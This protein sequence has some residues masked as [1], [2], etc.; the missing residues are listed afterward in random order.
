[1]LDLRDLIADSAT[2]P[3]TLDA[4]LHFTHTG[5]DTVI[6]VKPDGAAGQV[7]QTIVLSG[8]DLTAN[9]T[10]ND[11]TIIQDLLTKGKLITD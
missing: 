8:V 6:D 9:G 10:L 1:V 5:N 11:Q 3:A 7:T 2:T 4:Y